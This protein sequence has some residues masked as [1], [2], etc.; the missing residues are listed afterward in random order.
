MSDV[1]KGLKEA[2]RHAR[3]ETEA[4]KWFQ[5]GVRA[6]DEGW[7]ETKCPYAVGGKAH[8]EW[9]LGYRSRR[10]EFI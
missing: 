6:A 5:L 3:G 2:V 1:V 8:R 10:N 4:T 9:M 7:L